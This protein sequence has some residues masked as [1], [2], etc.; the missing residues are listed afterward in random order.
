MNNKK[1]YVILS[2]YL[3]TFCGCSENTND[4]FD[5]KQ[6]DNI[7][8]ISKNESDSEIIAVGVSDDISCTDNI[9]SILECKFTKEYINPVE[10][11]KIIS[12]DEAA[13]D[14]ANKLNFKEYVANCICERVE[15]HSVGE[16]MRCFYIFRRYEEYPDHRVT[17]GWYAVDI[18]TGK[19]FNTNVL[20][21]WT[22]L[23]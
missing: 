10:S 11:N 18:E 14:L 5:V 12:I 4:S 19:C 2:L 1:M 20:T 9:E 7:E 21:E 15:F 16:E 13:S 23:E 8:L 22:V 6:A 17:T 3:L